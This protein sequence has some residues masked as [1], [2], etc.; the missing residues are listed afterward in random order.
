MASLIKIKYYTDLYTNVT[1]L[2]SSCFGYF[3]NYVCV[4][5]VQ[6]SPGPQGSAA[7]EAKHVTEEGAG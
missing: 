5:V 6:R 3:H 1:L 7:G 2:V 4:V